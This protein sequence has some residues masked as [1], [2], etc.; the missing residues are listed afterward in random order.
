MW[1][2]ICVSLFIL[3]LSCL[4]EAASV[5]TE[6]TLAEQAQALHVL[7]RLGYGPRPGDLD[8]VLK[9]GVD[10]Y[11]DEQL[12]PERIPVDVALQ[13]RLDALEAQ[14]PGR[15]EILAA[16]MPARTV[17]DQMEREEQ[18]RL[19]QRRLAE[20]RNSQRLLLAIESPRQLQEVMVDF[21]FNHFNVYSEK[22][23][24]RVLL[25]SYEKE[26]IRPYVLGHFVQLLS[27]TAHHPAMLFYLD[28]WRS[29]APATARSFEIKDRKRGDGINEN[30]ARELMELH[31]LGVDGGYTQQDVSELAR[32]LTGWT[33][34]PREIDQ[35]QAAFRFDAGAHDTGTKIWMGRTVTDNGAQEGEMALAVLAMH[36]ATARHI[37]YKLAQ[38]FVADSPPPALV[39]RLSDKYLRTQGDIRALLTTLFASKEFKSAAFSNSKFKTPYQYVVSAARAAAMPVRNVRPY[40]AALAQLGQPLYGCLTPDGYKD[41]EVIWLNAEALTRR[42]NFALALTSGRL[43]LAADPNEE[44]GMRPQQ[45]AKLDLGRMTERPQQIGRVLPVS[46]DGLLETLGPAI[47]DAT[48]GQIASATPDMR[49]AMILGSPDF[50]R[51]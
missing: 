4:A 16:F 37:S 20:L 27:A 46:A 8:R 11:I 28:N 33:F 7:N 50:M 22:E 39:A 23:L 12:H 34:L 47:T 36:P 6:V 31:T 29:V 13:H 41:A 25:N 38:Y 48:R 18:R 30:Y 45:L 14:Q 43:P 44:Q 1:I 24:D 42:I 3:N 17:A 19:V 21:W 26:A 5:G 15:S 32:M 35:G 10:S 51:H 49:A 2:R 40:A 9:M